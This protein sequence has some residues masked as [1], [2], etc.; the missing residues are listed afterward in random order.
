VAFKLAK[1]RGGIPAAAETL[2]VVGSR[3]RH[4]PPVLVEESV[5]ESKNSST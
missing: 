2:E 4:E 1:R 3:V 5:S